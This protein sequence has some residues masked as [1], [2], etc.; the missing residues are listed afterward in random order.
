MAGARHAGCYPDAKT[1]SE[2]VTSYADRRKQIIADLR[3]EEREVFDEAYMTAGLAMELAE[4]VYSAR[5][6]A[7]LTPVAR[8]VGPGLDVPGPPGDPARPG[9]VA[10]RPGRLS[11]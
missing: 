8:P 7:G 2:N 11:F 4:T 10:R 6:A 1:R 9:L 5:E 3:P